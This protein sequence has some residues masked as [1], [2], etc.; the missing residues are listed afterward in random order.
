[1][2]D[3]SHPGPSASRWSPRASLERIAAESR[4]E[5]REVGEY[6]RGIFVSPSPERSSDGNDQF[7]GD[8]QSHDNHQGRGKCPVSESALLNAVNGLI[9]Q[10]QDYEDGAMSLYA[11]HV[12]FAQ[13]DASVDHTMYNLVVTHLRNLAKWANDNEDVISSSAPQNMKAIADACKTACAA[14]NRWMKAKI[15][16]EASFQ[17]GVARAIAPFA[18]QSAYSA[19][20]TYANKKSRLLIVR[21][22]DDYAPEPPDVSRRRAVFRPSSSSA[23]NISDEL[24]AIPAIRAYVLSHPRDHDVASTGVVHRMRDPNNPNALKP[25]EE[26]PGW[27]NPASYAHAVAKGRFPDELRFQTQGNFATAKQDKAPRH[28][29]LPSTTPAARSLGSPFT[30]DSTAPGS[31]LN[32]FSK[33]KNASVS[34]DA[35]SPVTKKPRKKKLK[36]AASGEQGKPS[37]RTGTGSSKKKRAHAASR[38]RK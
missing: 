27:L 31:A 28:D 19:T 37:P 8:D 4:L 17:D 13:L 20:L 24:M 16:Y 32:Y 2:D 3:T 23:Y 22:E 15:R 10:V 7:D 1:M 14:L 33:R 38:N 11:H 34:S 21:I 25:D 6:G 30:F 9:Q 12:Q 26:D 29:A 5:L 18:T 36:V 35:V